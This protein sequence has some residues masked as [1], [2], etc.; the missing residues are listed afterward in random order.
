MVRNEKVGMV[1]GGAMVEGGRGRRQLVLL[2][3][4]A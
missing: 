1:E 4:R 2:L 3:G